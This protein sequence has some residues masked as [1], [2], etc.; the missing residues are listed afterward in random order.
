M[1]KQTYWSYVFTLVF[2][3]SQFL[4]RFVLHSDI[5]ST[6]EQNL[7]IFLKNIIISV[8]LLIALVP[9]AIFLSMTKSLGEFTQLDIF[10]SRKII[11]RTISAIEKMGKIDTI[12]FEK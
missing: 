11:F 6:L 8:C 3:I 5:P 12:V 2:I 10:K 4:I 1:T 7:L 9:E